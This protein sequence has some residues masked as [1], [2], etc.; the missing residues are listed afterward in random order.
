MAIYM[1]ISKRTPTGKLRVEYV[2]ADQDSAA[3]V[4]NRATRKGFTFEHCP[5]PTCGAAVLRAD[6]WLKNR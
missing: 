6:F 3:A 4:A 2:A 1:K 5:R